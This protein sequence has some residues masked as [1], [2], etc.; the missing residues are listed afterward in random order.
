MEYQ[1]QVIRSDNSGQTLVINVNVDSPAYTLDTPL[2]DGDYYAQV[3]A[4]NATGKRSAFSNVAP[5]TIDTV[6]PLV[7]T[8]LKP[9]NGALTHE[10]NPQFDWTDSATTG[11]IT[12]IWIC[13]AMPCDW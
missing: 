8:L 1:L 6:S 7:P 13:P 3:R 5:M 2:A 12:F 9:A 11:M 4:R 10:P